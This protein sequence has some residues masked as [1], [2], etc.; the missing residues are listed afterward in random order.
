MALREGSIN[1]EIS[2]K[3]RRCQIH[4]LQVDLQNKVYPGW[5]NY[6]RLY[7]RSEDYKLAR[8]CDADYARYHDTRRSSIRYVFKLSS[9]T[10]SWCSKKQSI[11]TLLTREAEYRAAVGVAQESTWLKL[12]MED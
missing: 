5:I 11:V 10:T 9:R 4:L 12:L 8:Y 7:K 6:D 2:T 3:T 1:L